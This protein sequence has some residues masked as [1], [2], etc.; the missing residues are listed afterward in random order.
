M[1]KWTSR[2]WWAFLITE[3]AGVLTALGGYMM[4]EKEIGFAGLAM[5]IAAAGGYWKAEK[6]V[7]MARAEVEAA[8]EWN[9]SDD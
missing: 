3:G 4:G 9:K 2:K 6:D 7:D 8:K 1:S 5:M